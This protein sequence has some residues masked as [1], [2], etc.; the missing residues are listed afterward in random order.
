MN[1]HN[2]RCPDFLFFLF[3]PFSL[4][5]SLSLSLSPFSQG[6]RMDEQRCTFPPTLKVGIPTAL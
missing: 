6:N 5:L 3:P 2:Y 1:M 4:S